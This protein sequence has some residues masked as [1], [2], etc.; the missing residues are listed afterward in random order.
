MSTYTQFEGQKASFEAM[1]NAEDQ[2][3]HNS[4]MLNLVSATRR[5]DDEVKQLEERIAKLKAN[6]VDII[7]YAKTGD[8]QDTTKVSELFRRN[9][10]APE[11]RKRNW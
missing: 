9:E 8:L 11:Y 4:N 7:E 6:R 10:D 2:S 5:I 1:F 3:L